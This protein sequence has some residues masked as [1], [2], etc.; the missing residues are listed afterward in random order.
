MPI[1][2]FLDKIANTEFT[3]VI[4][5]SRVIRLQKLEE[6]LLD[7]AVGEIEHILAEI[8]LVALDG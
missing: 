3:H 1:Q 2:H 7:L 5:L 6:R 4:G 8:W